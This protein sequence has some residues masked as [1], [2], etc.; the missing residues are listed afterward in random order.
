M[1]RGLKKYGAPNRVLVVFLIILIL[2]YPFPFNLTNSFPENLPDNFKWS[3][4]HAKS[5]PSVFPEDWYESLFWMRNNTPD[6]GVNYY[7]L[8]EEPPRGVDYKYPESAYGVMSWWDYGHVITLYAHRIPNSNPFQGGIGGRNEDGS[9]RPGACTFFVSRDEE[10]ANWILDELGTRY[11]VS[12]FEM[13]DVTGICSR[14]GLTPKFSAITAWAKDTGGYIMRV[15]TEKGPQIAPTAKYYSTMEARLHLFDGTGVELGKDLYLQPLRHYRL[16]HE[17]PSTIISMGWQGGQ[18]IKF[19]KV[20]EYV[21]GARV[22]G[23]VE[24]TAP[25]GSVVE[26][27][28]NVT[29]NQGREFV[30]SARTLSNGTYSFVVPYS[31]EGTDFELEGFTVAAPYKIKLMKNETVALREVEQSVSEEAVLQGK[32]VRAPAL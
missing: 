19:V 31:T 24:G 11:V 26:I 4:Y 10:E 7:E 5:G 13:A 14:L 22:E 27:S 3:Y 25:N 1:R 29:S 9:L 8:Y 23:S 20:F 12:D 17:S 32:T 2:F 21:K 30:Y 28:T 18:E 16:V 6:P 15:N